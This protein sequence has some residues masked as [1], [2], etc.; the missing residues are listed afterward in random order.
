MYVHRHFSLEGPL[1]CSLAVT[2]LRAHMKIW[3]DRTQLY[4]SDEHLLSIL[5]LSVCLSPMGENA[6]R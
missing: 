2:A 5:P 4:N 6:R 1:E 3:Q